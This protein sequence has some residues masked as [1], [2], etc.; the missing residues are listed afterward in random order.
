[1]TEIRTLLLIDA[2]SHHAD[3]FI[4]AVLNAIDGPYKGEWVATLIF[5]R[6][7]HQRNGVMG[8]DVLREFWPEV[9]RKLNLPFRGSR[10]ILRP[11]DSVLR[12]RQ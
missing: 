12:N 9:S 5:W 3:V 11:A 10:N 7:R 6:D 2:D 4:D 1:M 8:F